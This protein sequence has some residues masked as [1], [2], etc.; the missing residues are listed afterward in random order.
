MT[1][2]NDIEKDYDINLKIDKEFFKYESVKKVSILL[3]GHQELPQ[4]YKFVEPKLSK[5]GLFISAIGKAKNDNEDD[6][7]FIW[8]SD[9][10]NGKPN[11]M[12]YGTSKIEIFEFSPDEN[13]FVI[14]YKNKP[15]SFYDYKKE[16]MI[17]E[18][19]AIEPD[20]KKIL[21]Y[22]F[23][24]KGDRF[25]VATDKDFIVYNT[26]TGKIYLQIIDDSKIKIFRGKILVLID[27][28]FN[29]KVYELLNWKKNPEQEIK[30]AKTYFDNRHKLKKQFQLTSFGNIDD[31]ITIKLSPDK[32]YIYFIAKDG[33][34]RISIEKE[35]M[36]KIKIESDIVQ[37]EISDD[38]DLF[39]TTDMITATF[40]DFENPDNIGY[41]H[42][43]KFNSFS[44]NFPQCKLLTADDLCIDITDIKN[45]LSQQKFIWLNLN[46]SQFLSFSFS[47]DYKVLLAIIDEFSAISYNCSTG[48]VIKKWKILLPHW[49]RACLMVPE[50]S[51][52]GVIATKSYNK[53]I[54]IWDYLSGTDLSTFT[55][56]DANNFSFSKYG[57]FLAAGTTQG[58]EIIR[59]WNLKKDETY[60]FYYKEEDML[61][62]NTFVKIHTQNNANSTS[63]EDIIGDLKIIAVAEGQN[64]LIFSFETKQLI[65]E[66]TGCPIQL[67]YMEDIQSQEL[68]NLFLIYGKCVNHI[69]T[70]ILFDL[71]G[72]MLGE[73]ENCKH[74]EFNPVNKGLLN[75][76]DDIKQ[77][78][79]SIIEIDE[80]NNINHIECEK[81]ELNSKFLSDGKN[82]IS[83]KDEDEN[84][85]TI[86]FNEVTNGETIGEIQFE[87]KTDNFATL[88]LNL[89]KKTN[90][91]I[92]RY[93]ELVNPKP[94]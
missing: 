92:F 62:K 58:D 78:G 15:P 25:V 88:S 48:E 55:G 83:I 53:I 4:K 45:K 94:K 60:S 42:K 52:I 90:C 93:I 3:K 20:N 32:N 76:S 57:Q 40:W 28:L 82:I 39:M 31:I 44:I 77:N 43:E 80:Q 68:F 50:T 23:S 10:L 37:G 72:E 6:A 29:I 46:P 86:F 66:V 1:T 17:V 38:A 12:F 9:R 51:S 24:K 84:K 11:L 8:K 41:I 16:K 73:F 36:N 49:S 64:P 2:K 33:I 56:F 79:M 5:N 74:I 13:I 91:I 67:E 75:F 18:C 14:I 19:Q 87:K 27:I 34:Y 30:E 61:N 89:D 81:S 59:A 63:K 21:S 22:A 35:E 69:P 54:K 70:A 65:L 71:N 7:V 85:K 26:K 47:P